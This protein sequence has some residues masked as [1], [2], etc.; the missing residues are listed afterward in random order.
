[1]SRD[2]RYA[3]FDLDHT[4]LPYDTQ[5]LLAQY[6]MTREP[7]R[8][9]YLLWF[10][11]CLIPAALKIFDFRM[12]KRIFSSYLFGMPEE[13]LK[14]YAED[15]VNEVVVNVAYPE[16]VAEII[17]LKNEGYTLILNS[18]SP[19]F[20]VREIARVWGFHHY[21]GT[22][23]ILAD[24]MPILPKIEGPNNKFAAKITAMKDRRLIPADYEPAA[25]PFLG[26]WAFSD[27][28]ADIPLL[29]IAEHAVTIHPGKALAAKAA[30]KGWAT[31]LP[32]RPYRGKWGGKIAT[33][34]LALGLG[35][36][37]LKDS[38]KV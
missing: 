13:R 11:P 32:S 31:R 3:F 6:V 28:P 9:V 5:V 38:R 27:S 24:P 1:M 14:K 33:L 19:E 17:R 16:I 22:N 10:I 29:S 36:K 4:I 23:L 15:F 18:A 35:K 34:R 20:Y 25:G 37:Y 26:S 7:W 12:M 2:I 21:I 8:R 30:E